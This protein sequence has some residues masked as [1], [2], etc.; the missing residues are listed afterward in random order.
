V[1]ESVKCVMAGQKPGFVTGP[2]S[3]GPP[4]EPRGG[5]GFV[6]V[7][8][9]FVR[10]CRTGWRLFEA[11]GVSTTAVVE[12]DFIFTVRLLQELRGTQFGVISV[13]RWL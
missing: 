1:I 9:G 5:T 13:E 12:K 3:R 11:T 6:A 2:L 4:T 8:V 10:V 7:L